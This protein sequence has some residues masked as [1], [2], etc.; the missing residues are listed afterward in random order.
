MSDS[1]RNLLSE[2]VLAVTKDWTK[3]KKQEERFGACEK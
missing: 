3:I 2:G 1:I